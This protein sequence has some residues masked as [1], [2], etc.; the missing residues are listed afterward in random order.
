MRKIGCFI[1]FVEFLA[2]LA[3]PNVVTCSRGLGVLAVLMTYVSDLIAVPISRVKKALILDIQV[4]VQDGCCDN[5][6][7]CQAAILSPALSL[8][9]DEDHIS[10]FDKQT[11]G[12]NEGGLHPDIHTAL[13]R[14]FISQDTDNVVSI[15]A[16]VNIV[17]EY[18]GVKFTKSISY[19]STMQAITES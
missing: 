14:L 9:V 2:L 19:I 16:R 6:P 17:P 8:K 15:V 18:R 13:L 5:V 12:E 4:L 7:R 3:V 11:P 10:S 1:C